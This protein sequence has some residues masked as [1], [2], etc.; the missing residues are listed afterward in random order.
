M[1]FKIHAPTAMEYFSALVQSDA[2]FPLLEA[3]I[4]LTQETDPTLDMQQVL[5]MCDQMLDRLKRRIAADAPALHRLRM[6]NQ[7]FFSE[8]GFACNLNDQDD[9][10]NFHMPAVLQSRR[11]SPMALAV[12]WLELAQGL[13]LAAAGIGLPGR[14]MVKVNLPNAQVVIDLLSGRSLSPEDL[15][16]WLEPLRPEHDSSEDDLHLFLQATPARGVI[17]LMLRS[18][19]EIYRL[20]SDWSRMIAVLTRLLVLLPGTIDAYRDRGLAYAALGET[21]KAVQDLA[22]YLDDDPHAPD[23]AAVSA[24]LADLQR[25]L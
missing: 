12:I 25:L 17:A 15:S 2:Q 18:L 4:S 19:Q 9:P 24:C 5:N 1:H 23:A 7:Y 6:L 11:G 10:D 3:A 21:T 20:R 14:F 8:L 22:R 16:E 13:G